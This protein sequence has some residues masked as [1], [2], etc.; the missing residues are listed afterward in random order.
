MRTSRWW[1]AGAVTAAAMT[2]PLA[3]SGTAVAASG[4]AT[5]ASG[6]TIGII[7]RSG[8]P[9]V[10]GHTLVAHRGPAGV[11]SATVS[12]S[13]SGAAKGDRAT[14]WF[15]SFRSGKFARSRSVTLSG[16]RN[17]PYSFSVRPETVT[18]YQVRVSGRGVT[19]SPASQVRN[20]YVEG[21]GSVSGK[22]GCSRP[23]CR[24]TLRLWVTIPASAYRTEAA[25]HWYLYLG[26][27]LSSWRTPPAP[28]SLSLSHTATASKPQRR[29]LWQ[30]AVTLRYRFRIGK[31]DG[32]TWRVNFC[33][34]DTVTADGLGL[35]GHHGC[36]DK[37]ISATTGYLG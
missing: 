23:V 16:S 17:A 13:V 15:K 8:L 2:L 22:R 35:P 33:T 19:G 18:S 14:L 12:G 9:R 10:S 20:V 27:R 24:I 37:R 31:S 6:V 1:R 5:A 4:A 30:F 28:R 21:L 34:R 29:H 25:K 32:Y 7:A 3:L 26:L 11:G 36:G